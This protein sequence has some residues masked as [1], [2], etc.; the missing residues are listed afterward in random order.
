MDVRVRG[1]RARTRTSRRPRAT[2]AAPTYFWA[3]QL[4]SQPATAMVDGGVFAD[5]TASCGY[6]EM[7]ELRGQHDILGVWLGT[8]RA[9]KPIQYL[10]ERT[11][12][13]I[14]WASP[15]IHVPIGGVNGSAEHQLEWRPANDDSPRYGR[16][17]SALT[18]EVGSMDHTSPTQ[19]RALQQDA[20]KLILTSNGRLDSLCE[21]LTIGAP[22]P[23]Q[24]R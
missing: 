4:A 15:V 7:I 2:S 20:A 1:E 14:G 17:R 13:L 19:V 6:V 10:E 23:G 18:S 22:A 24:P 3:E 21:L 16:F 12:G 8:S 5:N 9:T 11:W